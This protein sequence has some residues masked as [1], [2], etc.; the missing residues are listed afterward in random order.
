[1]KVGIPKEKRQ[2][3]ARV[4]GSPD[5]VKKLVAMGVEVVVEASAGAGA[6]ITDEAFTEAGATIAADAAAVYGAADMLIRVRRPKSRP[7]SRMT[8]TAA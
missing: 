2:G 1:M 5:M 3:E 6:M 8:V 4:A 7:Q